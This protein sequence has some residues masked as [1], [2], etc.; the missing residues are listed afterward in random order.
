M[1][2]TLYQHVKDMVQTQVAAQ[3]KVRDFSSAKVEIA[4]ADH[5]SWSAARDHLVVVKKAALEREKAIR[6]RGANGNADDIARI[7]ASFNEKLQLAEHEI[8]SMPI[9]LNFDIDMKYNFLSD[10]SSSDASSC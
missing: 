6:V 10:T 8:D 1:D 3:V 7:E 5:T 9:A 4:P 2:N